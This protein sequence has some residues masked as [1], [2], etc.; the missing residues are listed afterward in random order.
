[1]DGS[2]L[3]CFLFSFFFY[4]IPDCDDALCFAVQCVHIKVPSGSLAALCQLFKIKKKSECDK[5]HSVELRAYIPHLQPLHYL[6][7]R[8][9]RDYCIDKIR[10]L[11]I[12]PFRLISQFFPD[13]LARFVRSSA[14]TGTRLLI[15]CFF[16]GGEKN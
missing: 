11:W 4:I 3:T 15:D 13:F 12:V 2:S 6:V 8:C 1:M 14:Q 9:S 16:K 10:P 5:F 7:F